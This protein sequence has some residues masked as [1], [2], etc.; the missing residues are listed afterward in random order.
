MNELRR[1]A[2]AGL[3]IIGAG[4]VGLGGWTAL[5]PLTGAIVAPAFVKVDL[6]RKVVQHA[7]GGI[8]REIRVRDGDRVKQGQTLVVLEDVKVDANLDLLS[9]QLIAE[10]A[11]AA[12]LGTEAAFVPKLAFPAEIQRREREPRVAEI[13]D[14]ERAL[15]QSRRGSLEN[16]LAALRDQARETRAESAALLG[17]IAAEDRAIALQKEELR[18][19]E[20]LLRQNFVQKIRVLTLQ[21][22]VA[23]YEVK[24]GEHRADLA[25]SRQKASELALR[26][27]S[28]QNTYKQTAVDEMKD[29]TAH[30]FDLEERLRPSRDAAE[31]QRVVAPIA[32]EVVGLRVFTAGA[33]AGP[34][35][36]LL[37]IV[38][39]DKTLIVEARI[40]PEDINH[41]HV[42]SD[43]E[44][45]L[46]AYKQR[47]TPLVG[48]R[49]SYVSGDRLVD[50][51]NK[52][53]AYYVAQV[54]VPPA[55]LGELKMQAG[56]PAE[57]YVR[58]DTRSVLDYLLA[59]VTAYLRRAMREPV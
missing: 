12:R 46:T 25:R 43:A 58:T 18:A 26:I 28:A 4:V 29:A 35:D 15:F 5:A 7:E 3:A 16:Q 30:I 50:T 6:N 40:R 49:V 2:G 19:N 10:H 20:E 21:R 42:G 1:L 56:M 33:V 45:R 23:E 37:E 38:P 36:V 8:V 53:A 48:G 54:E 52:N 13:L 31:R 51:E 22:A 14:R 24:H 47:T 27:V 11:K 32:G 59:P 41:V 34:R 55:S 17:Q 39:A 44:V 57:V 9:I